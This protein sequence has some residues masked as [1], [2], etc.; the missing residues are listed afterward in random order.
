MNIPDELHHIGFVIANEHEEFLHAWK[1][2]P[3]Y[4]L[5]G[6]ALSPARAHVFQTREHASNVIRVLE[7][8]SKLWILDLFDSPGQFVVSTE[9]RNRPQWLPLMTG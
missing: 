3:G 5:T 9:S 6:W 1:R 4:S 7:Y 8:H 2:H